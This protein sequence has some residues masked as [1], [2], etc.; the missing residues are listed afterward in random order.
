MEDLAQLQGVP[1]RPLSASRSPLLQ[2]VSLIS[3]PL[4]VA[5]WQELLANHPDEHFQRF[6]V[7]GIH[8]GFHIGFNPSQP[9]RSSIKN[10]KSAYEHPMVVQKYLDREV[11]L[12]RMFKIKVEEAETLQGL[13]LNPFGVIPKRGRPG[14]WRLIVNLSFPDGRSV[15]DRISAEYCSISYTTVDDAVRIIRQLG[16]ARGRN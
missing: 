13:Q 7:D 6:I 14:K 12:Q 1:S 10:M 11:S 9:K 2:R 5:A 16:R 8:Q 3:L 4:H 15:N